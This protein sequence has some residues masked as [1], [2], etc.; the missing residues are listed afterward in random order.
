MILKNLFYFCAYAGTLSVAIVAWATDGLHD[1]QVKGT[2]A[3]M[4]FFWAFVLLASFLEPLLLAEESK[5]MLQSI[6]YRGLFGRGFTAAA[7]CAVC[8]W[9]LFWLG[10]EFGK[11]IIFIIAG[12]CAAIG[13]GFLG[14]RIDVGKAN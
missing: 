3:L 8:W 6:S 14:L 2:K 4:P 10:N 12:Y 7:I 13:L 1:V 11:E 9:I 5:K